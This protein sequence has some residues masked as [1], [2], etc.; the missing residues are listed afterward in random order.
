MT[1]RIT[2]PS[3]S[4]PDLSPDDDLYIHEPGARLDGKFRVQSITLTSDREGEVAELECGLPEEGLEAS[5][6][7]IWKD[8]K[9]LGL[10]PGDVEARE[11]EL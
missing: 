8:A 2:I 7:G 9:R 1:I 4:V 11:S 10:I 5:L 3:D 6:L